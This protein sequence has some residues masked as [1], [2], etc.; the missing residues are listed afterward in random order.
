MISYM[1][2]C[3]ATFQMCTL[4]MYVPVRTFCKF[5]HDGTYRYVPVQTTSESFFLVYTRYIPGIYFSRWYSRNIPGI[6]PHYDFRIKSCCHPFEYKYCFNE[7]VQCTERFCCGMKNPSF[8]V[9]RWFTEQWDIIDYTWY[10]HGICQTYS[11]IWNDWFIGAK[12]T[13]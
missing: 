13:T 12:K 9:I 7:Y 3:S 2:S 11:S 4:P 10:M 6:I 8:N 1:I 5:S